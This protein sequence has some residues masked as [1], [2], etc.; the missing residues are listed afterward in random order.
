MAEETESKA[1]RARPRAGRAAAGDV[2]RAC[3]PVRR[4]A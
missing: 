3:V 1:T 4:A 2:R